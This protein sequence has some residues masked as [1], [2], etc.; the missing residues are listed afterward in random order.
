MN[1][2]INVPSMNK[3][4]EDNRLQEYFKVL[5]EQRTKELTKAFISS[6]KKDI[7]SGSGYTSEEILI[8][9]DNQLKQYLPTELKNVVN[10]TGVLIHTNLGRAKISKKI[11]ESTSEKLAN[12]LNI[13]FDLEKGKR[14]ERGAYLKNIICKTTGA[15]ASLIVNNNASAVFLILNELAKKSEVIVSRGELVEI[16]GSFR[17]PDIMNM[18]GAKLKEIGTTNKTKLNDYINN[19]NENTTM[20]MKVH[21]SNFFLEGF[22]EE[23]LI[24]KIASLAQENNLISYYDVGSAIL[25]KD[26]SSTFEWEESVSEILKY[27]VDLVSFSGDKLLG[28]PQAGIIVGKREYIDRLKKNPLYRVLR[29]GKVT[30]TI[31]YETI[32]EHNKPISEIDLPFFRQIRQSKEILYNRA[33]SLGKRIFVK[34]SIIEHSAKVGGGS[35]PKIK[36]ESYAIEIDATEEVSKRAFYNLLALE[37][38]ILGFLKGSKLVLDVIAINDDDIEYI[39]SQINR[40]YSK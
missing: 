11:L 20:L 7:L 17:V 5:G 4:Y 19:I 13:E 29:V 10:C 40:E 37:K 28:G 12:Y 2:M 9:L 25:T 8:L 32:K 15:E 33:Y 1:E 35:L 6:I 34:T 14:G 24:D 16:G 30:E 38:P 18:S 31:L 26:S 21:R 22:T 3:I 23:V 39:T 36:L 27:G